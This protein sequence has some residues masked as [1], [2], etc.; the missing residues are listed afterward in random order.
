MSSKLP[1]SDEALQQATELHHQGRLSEAEHLYQQVLTR[2]PQ[3]FVAL[4]RLAV[5]SL[6]QAQFEQALQRVESALVVDPL[7]EAALMNRGTALLALGR[8]DEAV[9]VY[10]AVTKGNPESADAHFNLGNALMASGRISEAVESYGASLSLRP[11]DIETLRRQ[12]IALSR[13][14]RFEDALATIEHAHELLPTSPELCHERAAALFELR[15]YAETIEIYDRALLL[16]V[17]DTVALNNRGLALVRISRP[18]EA[19]ESFDRAIEVNPSDPVLWY[20]RGTAL[21]ALD[22]TEDVFASYD[23]ALSIKPDHVPTLVDRGNLLQGLRRY[24]EAL[25]CFGHAAQIRPSEAN[26]LTNLGNAL[27][28]LRRFDE[29]L[30]AHERALAID[31][32]L[33][34]A[35][36][37]RG[38]VLKDLNRADEAIA[39]YERALAIQPDHAEALY[40]CGL[41]LSTLNRHEQALRCYER[42]LAADPQHRYA[43]GT[44][45][46][47][48]LHICNWSVTQS[49]EPRLEAHIRDRLSVITPFTVLGYF[50]DPGLQLACSKAYVGDALAAGLRPASHIEGTRPPRLPIAYLSSDFQ[51]H[52]MSFSI[53]EIFELHDRSRFEVIGVSWGPDDGS[54]VRS[55]IRN[56]CDTFLD[57]RSISDQDI[58]RQLASRGAAI[59]I[60][61]KGLTGNNRLGI[62]AHRPAPI[63]VGYFG[64]PATVG[65]GLIDYVLADPIIVPFEQQPNWAE[66]IVHLPG[67]YWPN[68]RQRAVP[69]PAFTRTDLGLPESGFV[70]CSFNNNWK[71]TPALFDIWM[72]LLRDFPD[73]VLWLL[74]DSE[75]AKNNLVREAEARGVSRGRLVFAA[76]AEPEMHLARHRFADLMLDTLPCNAHTTASDALWMAVPVVTCPGNSFAAR[77]ASSLLHAV[78]LAELICPNLEAYEATARRLAAQRGEL[79]SMKARLEANRLTCRLFDSERLCRNIEAAYLQMWEIHER[80]EA[81]RSF[82]VAEPAV[83]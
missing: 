62:Y 44:L 64:Y 81:P 83:Q 31:P 11:G 33:V 4:H 7:S 60:D 72:G 6:Q 23:R 57:A 12:S 32:N 70:F 79:R 8:S 58:A 76:R 50:D 13:L 2:Q 56:A 30:T 74:E 54:P 5:I 39:S 49:I 18:L 68:D 9:A 43:L 46:D 48:A 22:R 45:A 40:N 73:S 29:A 34:E 75:A 3:N 67:C 41:A 36:I 55:R 42:A 80:G 1:S 71:I 17:G 78:D 65:G 16:N 69:T 19:V 63:H 27:R 14:G 66:R 24:E 35:L 25:A 52:S 61:L 15:R 59:A 82:A 28:G 37:N 38:I 21:R 77:V 51:R 10:Q 26:V 53:A 20:N 47:A